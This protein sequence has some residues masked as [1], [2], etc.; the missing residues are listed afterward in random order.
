MGKKG[1]FVCCRTKSRK[2]GWQMRKWKQNFKACRLEKKEEV[3]M[4]R[5]QVMAAWR[6]YGS[7][8][9]P[10]EQMD[11]RPLHKSSTEKWEQPK[12][13]CQEEK[14]DEGTVKMNE[15]KAEPVSN[16]SCQRQAGSIKVHWRVVWS[17][18]FFV[19]GVHLVKTEVQEDQPH[20]GIA[21]EDGLLWMKKTVAMW[22]EWCL[23]QERKKNSQGKDPRTFEAPVKRW[24]VQKKRKEKKWKRKKKRKKKNEAQKKPSVDKAQRTNYELVCVGKERRRCKGERQT[25]E[26]E[27][28]GETFS[29]KIWKMASFS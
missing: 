4:H 3:V 20:K 19:F 7:N 23:Q 16:W 10:W 6:P 5:R 2:I 25:E 24:L 28:Q 29:G 1:V 8:S 22:E 14:K 17:L 9:S 21:R 26:Q 13:R 18:I 27:S 15:S 12:G 11:L